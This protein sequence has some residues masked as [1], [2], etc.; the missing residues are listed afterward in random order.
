[1][2][3]RPEVRVY[4]NRAE[5]VKEQ[6]SLTQSLNGTWRFLFLEA[7]EYSPADFWKVEYD[8]R[9]WDSLDVPSTWQT[10]GYGKMHYTDVHYLFPICPPYV[11]NDNPTGIYRRKF[12]ATGGLQGQTAILKFHG[13]ECL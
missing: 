7:P 6:S 4:R 3:A 10:E 1:M 12:E 8:D 9:N 11:P 2:A 13:V 5:A